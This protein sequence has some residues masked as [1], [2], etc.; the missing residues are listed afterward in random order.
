[1]AKNLLLTHDMKYL[2]T[3]AFSDYFEPAMVSLMSQEDQKRVDYAR[4]WLEQ[5]MPV[6]AEVADAHNAD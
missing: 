3:H 1:M 2:L 4:R 5:Q 6:R